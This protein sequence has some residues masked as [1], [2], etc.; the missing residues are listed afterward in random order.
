M[1][2]LFHYE[3][4]TPVFPVLG[5]NQ[6][7]IPGGGK[8]A[9][10]M[11][12][13]SSCC[14]VL[15]AVGDLLSSLIAWVSVTANSSKHLQVRAERHWAC[16]SPP[17]A[18]NISM[19][20]PMVWGFARKLGIDVLLKILSVPLR[21][22]LHNSD[23]CQDPFSAFSGLNVSVQSQQFFLYFSFKLIVSSKEIT[24]QWKY[25]FNSLFASF[26]SFMALKSS[27]LG[28]ETFHT[29]LEGTLVIF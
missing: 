23:K 3:L 24:C 8:G 20:L 21:D 19:A 10:K 17:V 16:T 5:N 29:A 12:E 2:S 4:H 22:W 15:T 27:I 18:W 1:K 14:N 13:H 9:S 25:N 28:E 11:R 6:L 26:P 7:C